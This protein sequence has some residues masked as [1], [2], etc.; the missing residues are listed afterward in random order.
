[1]DKPVPLILDV[2]G[3][4]L[5]TDMLYE[6]FWSAFGE[7]PFATLRIVLTCWFRPA[8]L[9]HDLR[10]VADP[11]VERLPVR[12]QVMDLA[13]AAAAVGRDVHLASGS[14]VGLVDSLAAELGFG[15]ENFG[16]T[17]E[18]NLTGAKKA[19]LLRDRYGEDGF[20]Y[21]GNAAVDLEVWQHSRRVIAVAPGQTLKRRLAQLDKPVEILDHAWSLKDLFRELRP[22]QWIKNLLLFVPLLIALPVPASSA[23]SVLVA[24]IAFSL[25]ASAIY[26]INDLLDLDTDRQHPEKRN[27]PVASGRLPIRAAMLSSLILGVCSFSLA[28][29]V[30]PMVAVLTGAYMMTSLVYSLWLKKLRWIDLGTL[31]TLFTLRFVTGA[32]AAHVD[33]SLWAAVTVFAIFLALASV[34]RVTALARSGGTAR[35][36][37][38]GYSRADLPDVTKLAYVSAAIAIVPYLAYV[39][40][41]SSTGGEMELSSQLLLTAA[42]VPLELWLLRVIRFGVEGREDYDPVVF[43]THDK[44]GLL[45]LAAFLTMLLLGS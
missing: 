17:P 3:T 4:L 2:D 31:A 45:L 7:N 36:P 5:R 10:S 37:G 39:S 41:V 27:R 40:S 15:N 16:S 30:N 14:D 12:E 8:Q 28:M 25:G 24:V 35:L 44:P 26:I 6:A 11:N 32:F 29:T 42:I 19:R 1:M 20:D 18:Q 38:R 43:V 13:L 9:K 22:H 23:V 34:K 33:F 21:A